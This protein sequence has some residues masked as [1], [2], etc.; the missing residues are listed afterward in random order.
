MAKDYRAAIQLLNS[1][2]TNAGI[3]EAVRKSGNL[4]NTLSIPEMQQFLKRIGHSDQDLNKLNVIHI[5]GTKGKGSTSAFCDSMLRQKQT[6]GRPLKVG[7]FTS[8]HIQQ[9]RERIRIN[10][11]PIDE[12]LFAKHFFTVWDRLEATKPAVVDVHNPD[13]PAYFRY[14]TLMS[15]HVF[16]EEQVDAAVIEVG[17]GGQYDS[18]N[19][20]PSPVCCAVTSLGFDHVALLGN[21]IDKIA[22]HKSGVFK[23]DAFCVTAPQDPE[24][25][26]V[27]E[28]RAK[29]NSVQ[30]LYKINEKD[31]EEMKQ[32]QIGLQGEHQLMNAAVAKKLVDH[33]TL[34]MRKRGM[35]LE[36]DES[37][38]KGLQQTR[39]PGRCQTFVSKDYPQVSWLLD[40]AH[41]AESLLACAKW[42]LTKH[43][44]SKKPTLIFNCT[45]ERQGAALFP[46]LI[47][48]LKL[49]WSQVIFCSNDLYKNAANS[50][51]NTSYNDKKDPQL[52]VQQKLAQV[53]KDL[54]KEANYK[55]PEPFVF[56]SIQEA[57]EQSAQVSE[58]VLVTGSLYLVGGALTVLKAPIE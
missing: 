37:F 28:E 12:E 25:I 13:K 18:T 49:E 20:I 7:L 4:L 23:K 52:L 39:W 19:V 10:G 14:L 8:P 45:H 24:A 1:L 43:D 51:D 34:E 5:A 53:W 2:Q 41:T 9:V 57:I 31:I 32:Y 58:Q 17:V 47:Q 40:G 48:T 54:C 22:W 56:G 38:V 46:P 15:F 44:P 26:R 30:A 50:A 11:Q 36:N 42:Y 55:T 6:A 16:L 29:E 27:I 33:W 3:I 35:P 21:T